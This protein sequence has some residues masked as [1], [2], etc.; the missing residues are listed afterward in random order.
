MAA[1][2]RRYRLPPA[3]AWA[4]GLLRDSPALPAQLLAVAVLVVLGA[5]EAG[6]GP[7]VWYPA[8]LFL[9]GLLAVTLAVIGVPARPRRLVLAGL[10]LLGAYAAWCYVSISWAEQQADAWDGGNRA[11]AYLVVLALFSL[12]PL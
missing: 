4:R 12:W 6:F 1:H 9:L 3:P 2:P 8:A 5:S 11:C 10:A 7:T